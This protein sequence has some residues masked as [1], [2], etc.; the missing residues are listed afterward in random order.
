MLEH[1]LRL[2][3]EPGFVLPELP[4]EPRAERTFESLSWPTT[5]A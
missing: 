2:E 1:Q 4:G 3:A 5:I